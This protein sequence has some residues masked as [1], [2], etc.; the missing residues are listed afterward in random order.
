MTLSVFVLIGCIVALLFSDAKEP[1]IFDSDVDI[2][3]NDSFVAQ[4]LDL[5]DSTSNF[6]LPQSEGELLLID[7]ATIP[8]NI[9]VQKQLLV[10][11]PVLYFDKIRGEEEY[12]NILFELLGKANL[13]QAR[14]LSKYFVEFGK[15]ENIDPLF[16]AAV[17]FVDA[18]FKLDFRREDR[19]GI[20]SL[21]LYSAQ[22]L[23]R[24]SGEVSPSIDDLILPK[25]NI[26]NATEYLGF[27][28]EL[29]Q[30]NMNHVL[31]AYFDKP[32]NISSA[33][34]AKFFYSADM[35]YLVNTIF[36]KYSEWSIGDINFNKPKPPVKKVEPKDKKVTK[37]IA[38][39]KEP[40]ANEKIVN[41][42]KNKEIQKEVAKKLKPPSSF[43]TTTERLRYILKA[44]EVPSDKAEKIIAYLVKYG[45]SYRIDPLF[46]AAIVKVESNFDWSFRSDDEVTKYGLFGLT[47]K[48]GATI[49]KR[50]RVAWGGVQEL[51]NPDY[52][53]RLMAAYSAS[54]SKLFRGN[55]KNIYRAIA[56]DPV[57]LIGAIKSR[58]LVP[59]AQTKI[60]D[61]Y[62]DQF[63]MWLEELKL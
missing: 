40:Q 61:V 21:N 12:S 15:L 33:L 22:F 46:L 53:T 60:G 27:L 18:N 44:S 48:K 16:L 28:R 19:Y 9:S 41:K 56:W 20:M 34:K 63:A 54:L 1:G 26:R 29:F 37:I 14:I 7:A 3:A 45:T 17:A 35:I 2:A 23:S 8:K 10:N 25:E 49:A 42:V 62:L 13:K 4:P 57:K 11:R 24:L 30:G 38:K 50:V 51:K 31:F 55:S 39:Q 47:E 59:K 36:D 58:K 6:N 5:T 32:E 43:N 52:T